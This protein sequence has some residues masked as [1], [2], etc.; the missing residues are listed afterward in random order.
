V[1]LR[2]RVFGHS[3]AHYITSLI[4]FIH[5]HLDIRRIIIIISQC[6]DSCFGSN[7]KASMNTKEENLRF[8]VYEKK[9]RCFSLS[10]QKIQVSST[11][12]QFIHGWKGKNILQG[13]DKFTE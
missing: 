8:V 3:F 5:I 9:G 1:W 11:S 4:A 13:M 12:K 6:T 7:D 2:K 10:A